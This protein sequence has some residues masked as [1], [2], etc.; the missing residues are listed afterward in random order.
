MAKLTSSLLSESCGPNQLTDT[1][2]TVQTAPSSTFISGGSIVGRK[3][4]GTWGNAGET[5]VGAPYA[6]ACKSVDS[7]LGAVTFEARV[8]KFL[9]PNVAAFYTVAKQF[10]EISFSSPEGGMSLLTGTATFI[11]G[12]DAKSNKIIV[13]IGEQIP[14]L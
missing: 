9:L 4:D 11:L 7:T 10:K 3:A 1:R 6:Q 13:S 5:G 8:G 14:S 12:L 2:I